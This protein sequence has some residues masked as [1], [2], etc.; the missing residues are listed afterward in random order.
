MVIMTVVKLN[1]PVMDFYGLN[2][3]RTLPDGNPVK[4]KFHSK[5]YE[6]AQLMWNIH[7]WPLRTTFS[8]RDD[9]DWE[10]VEHCR[11]YYTLPD[12]E[13][14]IPECAGEETQV[15]TILQRKREPA[16][17]FGVIVGEQ[18]A[19]LFALSQNHKFQLSFNLRTR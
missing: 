9:G 2:A 6:N 12:P 7:W 11:R 19:M 14:E 10:L 5:Q 8:R 1:E 17:S 16:Q 13:A 15:L 18:T 4:F 3:W